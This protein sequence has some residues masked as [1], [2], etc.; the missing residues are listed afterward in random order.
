MPCSRLRILLQGI[1][2]ENFDLM[3]E[4]DNY[5]VAEQTIKIEH[6]LLGLPDAEISDIQTVYSHPQ[7]LMQSVDF[8]N[9]HDAWERV[10]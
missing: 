10:P 9:A 3:L 8:L 4:Y 1:V 2:G 6:A 7:A 5:I